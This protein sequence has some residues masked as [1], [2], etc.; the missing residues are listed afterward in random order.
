MQCDGGTF[1]AP[2]S[3]RISKINSFRKWEMA[4]RVYATIYCGANPHRSKEICQYVSVINTSAS[5]FIWDNVYE[6]NITFRHL[7]AFN[8]A[9]SWA[10]TYSQMWN[11][12]MRDP[13]QKRSHFGGNSF[14]GNTYNSHVNTAGHGSGNGNN[15]N[16]KKKRGDY[17]WNFN[18]GIPCKFGKNCRFIERCKYCD[19]S[20]HGVHK[21]PKLVEKKGSVSGS[22]SEK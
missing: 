20:D 4:F 2:V 18:K 19:A 13:L 5:S 21:C 7:M 16:V 6:Y 22:G 8:P 15:G 17:C 11:I 1:L 14:R 9:R 3:D 12:C 10:V